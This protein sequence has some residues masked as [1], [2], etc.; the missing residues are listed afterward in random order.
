M[1]PEFQTETEIKLSAAAADCTGR[2]SS[3]SLG[4]KEEAKVMVVCSSATVDGRTVAVAV[5]LHIRP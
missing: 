2:F 5:G 1:R 4:K 3:F